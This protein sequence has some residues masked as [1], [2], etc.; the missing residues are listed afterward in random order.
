MNKRKIFRKTDL[1]IPAVEHT[2]NAAGEVVIPPHVIPAITVIQFPRNAT[3]QRTFDFAGWYGIGIDAITYALQRQVERFLAGQ[4]AERRVATVITYCESG[5]RHLLKYLALHSEA[6]RRP[7]LLKDVDREVIDGFLGS[8]R[9]K[10]ASIGAQRQ[11][12][13]S[14]KALLVALGRRGLFRLIESGDNTT[15]PRNPFPHGNRKVKGESPLSKRQRQSFTAAVKTAV[16]PLFEDGVVPTRD[17]LAYA[18]LVV[19]LH[20][21]RNT[22][23]LLEMT[24]D[25]LRPHPKDDTVFLVVYKNR[26]YSSSKV[27]MRAEGEAQRAI[28]STPSVRPTVARLIRRV[29]EVVQPLRSEAPEAIKNSVWLFRSTSSSTLGEI[30]SLTVNTLRRATSELIARYNLVDTDGRPLRINISRLRKTFI[31]RIY[32]ILDG[33][34]AT[35]AIAAGNTP[36]V[37]ERNY[38]RPGDDSQKNWKF[39]GQSLVTEL[40]TGKLGATERTPTGHCSDNKHGDYAPKKDGATCMSFT[41][42]LRCRNYVVT[43][44]DLYRLFSFYWRVLRERERTSKRKWEKQYAHIPRLID[45][46]VVAPGVAKK[47]FKQEDVDSARERARTD[48]HPFWRSHAILGELEVIQ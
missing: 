18:L 3:T 21:G 2:R 46:D 6:L 47:I 44:D 39:L 29:I 12:Y 8:L 24:P 32:E 28:E 41:N 9:D 1:R 36:Q 30:V 15:F 19:A 48:P 17:L 38:L 20:T 10:G 16:M 35:T 23:P 31:N 33:D 37:T 7:L 13:K 5:A 14:A 34:L 45:R 40:L 11:R 4:D 27:A 25:C 26:G 22:T 43:G 42:C